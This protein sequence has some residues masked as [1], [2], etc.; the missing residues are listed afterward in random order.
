LPI[1]EDPES[2]L[3]VLRIHPSGE[4]LNLRKHLQTVRGWL[5]EEPSLHSV[6]RTVGRR[7]LVNRR[8]LVLFSVS[9]I[10]FVLFVGGVFI[11]LSWYSEQV[12][13]NLKSYATRLEDN[14]FIVEPKPLSEFHVD[15]EQEW[16]EFSDFRSFAKQENVSTIYV[17]HGIKGLYYLTPISPI[18]DGLVANVFYYNR[19]F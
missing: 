9:L 19:V 14:G 1:G 5:P 12:L 10:C 11:F 3:V 17:D 4:N 6:K 16:Y 2:R 7:S 18:N 15:T 8:V 13:E